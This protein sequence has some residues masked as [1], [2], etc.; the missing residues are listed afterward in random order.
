[1]RPVPCRPRTGLTEASY[2]DEI[3]Y[4]PLHSV[5]A[6]VL[7][8]SD[9][10]QV[11]VPLGDGL[12]ATDFERPT[13]VAELKELVV[14][15]VSAGRSLYPQGGRTALDFGGVPRSAGVAI[16]T[17]GLNRV[18]DYPVADLTITIQSGITLGELSRILDAE[19]QRLTLDAPQGDR[20]SLGGIYAT[21]AAG[22]RRYGAGRPR[23]QILGVG[24]VTSAGEEVKGGGRVVKNVAGY[25]FPKLLTGSMGT[26]GIL[27]HMTLKV[28]PKPEASALAV[29]SVSTT[30]DLARALD[31]LNLS[32][33]RP[34]AIE[35]F[36]AEGAKG[37]G[38]EGFGDSPWSIVVGFEDNAPSVAWQL[39]RFR[40]EAAGH[41]VRI[42]D[43]E[44]A[45]AVWKAL[46]ECFAETPGPI[47]IEAN[48]PPSKVAEFASALDPGRW[49]LTARA[50]SGI[51]RA[52][53]LGEIDLAEAQRQIHGLRQLAEASGGALT[54]PRCPTL[55]KESLKVWGNPRP[56]WIWCERL[57]QTL[58]PAGALNPGRFVGKI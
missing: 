2:K 53:W 21:N 26:L 19:G 56:D 12:F 44:A 42:F 18:I 17:A 33:T 43:G 10:S 24:F 23:D 5:G 14:R 38:L 30:D 29:L 40:D 1:M 11:A 16:S 58:D 6:F 32:A 15:H 51:V 48:L 13:E 47:T 22:P 39:G 34:I 25:D 45:P 4:T 41:D 35:L 36:N 57:K 50:G 8:L 7:N 28:R 27:T 55:W 49:A 3:R 31:A 20:A 9:P 54:L 37:L 46:V 52:H